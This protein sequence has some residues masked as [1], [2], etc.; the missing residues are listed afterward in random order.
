MKK[1]LEIFSTR[2]SCRNFKNE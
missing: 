2:Y 1:E